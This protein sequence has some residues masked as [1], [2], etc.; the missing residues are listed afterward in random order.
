MDD[1]DFSGASMVHVDASRA[2]AKRANFRGATL[3]DANLFAVSFNGADM[4]GVRLSNAV[5]G[6][7][8]FGR[9][10][11]KEGAW[12]RLEGVDWEGALLSRSDAR[13]VCLNPTVDDE[14]RAVLGCR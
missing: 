10:G 12:A 11:G 7:A 5:M 9:D 6:N 1:A 2:S 4:R 3:S 14:G 13:N 8:T